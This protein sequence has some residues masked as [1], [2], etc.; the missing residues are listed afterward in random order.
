M[1]RSGAAK[2]VNGSKMVQADKGKVSG[3]KAAAKNKVSK[4]GS[5]ALADLVKEV[6]SIWEDLRPREASTD[7][8]QELVGKILKAAKG[9]LKDLAVK[10]KA[11]RVIQAL[12]KHGT[13]QQK[14]VVWKECKDHIIEL[15][16]SVYGNHVVRKLISIADKEQL[17]GVLSSLQS[18]NVQLNLMRG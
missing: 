5:S 14:E 2:S 9:K 11:S 4:K 17:S 15:S 16:M 3:V 8:K 12:L 10:S 6:L 13:K 18:T 7:V 1:S